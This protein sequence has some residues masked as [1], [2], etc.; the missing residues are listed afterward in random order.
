MK[1]IVIGLG[2]FGSSVAKLL[3]NAGHE[4]IGVDRRQ[5]KAEALKDHLSHTIALDSTDPLA[6]GMLP[7]K[8]AD[9]CIVAIGENEGASI[10]TTALLKQY[11]AKRII[12]RAVSALHETVL[13]AMEIT[14]IVHPEEESAERLAKKL[15]IKGVIDSFRLSDNFNVIEAEVPVEFVGQTIQEINFRDK[16]NV[17]LLTLIRHTEKRS[18]IGVVRSQ[19]EVLGVLPYDTILEKG[20]IMVIFGSMKDV[21]KILDKEND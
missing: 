11:K 3:H 18:V 17:V 4:V 10:M 7:L 15:H 12:S 9:I 16:H 20:D 6:V 19:N 13:E 14:E 8:T 1:F 2:N 5:E 21:Q